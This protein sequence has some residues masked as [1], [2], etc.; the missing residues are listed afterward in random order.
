M[1]RTTAKKHLATIIERLK[2]R[3]GVFHTPDCFHTKSVVNRAWVF[4]SYAKGSDNPNDLDILFE[5]ENYPRPNK[6]TNPANYGTIM[7]YDR[8]SIDV[9][10]GMKMVRIHHA[11]ID[12]KFGDIEQT[13]QLIFTRLVAT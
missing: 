2:E 13:K 5:F 12:G 9:R 10:K 6:E 7:S 4:G 3:K 11:S 1:K 8:V